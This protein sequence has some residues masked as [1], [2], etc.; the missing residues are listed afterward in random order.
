M[1]DR[2]GS[3]AEGVRAE[4]LLATALLAGGGLPVLV[5]G[6]G[7]YVRAALDDLDFPGTDPA[8]RARLPATTLLWVGGAGAPATAGNVPG[9]EVVGTLEAI[10]PALARWEAGAALQAPAVRLQAS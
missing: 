2:A 7:L 1:A 4:A 6:S 9:I 8:L 3:L 5:G 10:E